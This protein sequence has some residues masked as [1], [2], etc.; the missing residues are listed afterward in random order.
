MSGKG[1]GTILCY[2]PSSHSPPHPN[3]PAATPRIYTAPLHRKRNAWV[4]LSTFGHRR[5]LYRACRDETRVLYS[6][7]S[8]NCMA[9]TAAA[10]WIATRRYFR[11]LVTP[12]PDR[13]SLI[14]NISRDRL[15]PW[16]CCY[17]H[18]HPT[19]T[20][21][22]N[23]RA[24]SIFHTPPPTHRTIPPWTPLTIADYYESRLHPRC[25]VWLMR[26]Q[27]KCTSAAAAKSRTV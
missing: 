6:A 26:K 20:T 17:N 13:F 24:A 10:W 22:P 12:P 14:G 1:W 16:L 11:R 27:W 23:C 3:Q 19:T 5:H 25:I 4:F 15:F 21:Y 18:L 2:H 9:R 8:L 7:P